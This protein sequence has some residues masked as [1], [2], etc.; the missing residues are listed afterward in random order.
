MHRAHSPSLLL[1]KNSMLAPGSSLSSD[2][3]GNKKTI[4]W[5][6]TQEQL[7]QCSDVD[8]RKQAAPLLHPSQPFFPN[9]RNW[10]PDNPYLR[11]RKRRQEPKERKRSFSANW[12]LNSGIQKFILL[13]IRKKGKNNNSYRE[14]ETT[15][16]GPGW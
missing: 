2:L 5:P 13:K 3:R 7:G 14:A 4:S 8:L 9:P 12:D 1:P 16:C 11:D 15:N 6:E 10:P